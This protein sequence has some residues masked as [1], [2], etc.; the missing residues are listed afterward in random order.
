MKPDEFAVKA[1]NAI[2]SDRWEIMWPKEKAALAAIFAEAIRY[3]QDNCVHE[4]A[5][6]FMGACK[7]HG[8]GECRTCK[9]EPTEDKP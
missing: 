8:L 7:A 1:F 3:G 6:K 2:D 5:R 4:A 9:D